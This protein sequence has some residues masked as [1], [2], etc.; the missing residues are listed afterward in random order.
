M[1][2]RGWLAAVLVGVAVLLMAGCSDESTQDSSERDEEG[3]ITGGGDVGVF[4][5][6]VGD[7]FDD[8]ANGNVSEV[9]AVPC[10]ESHDNEVIGKFNVE[11]DDDADFPGD[12]EISSQ[13][14]E[15]CQGDIFTDYIGK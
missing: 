10:T 4:A 12:T 11:G 8:P 5:L 13:A 15:Q 1:S 2:R 3:N 6:A 14:T 7:C 9:E